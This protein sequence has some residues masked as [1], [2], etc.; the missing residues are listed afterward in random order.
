MPLK[1]LNVRII[2]VE[3]CDAHML[4]DSDRLNED[5]LHDLLKSCVV[6]RPIAWISTIGGNGLHNVA[7]FS[8]FTFVSSKPPYLGFSVA[9]KRG[10]KKGTLANIERTKDFVVNVVTEDLA[11]AV[12]LSAAEYPANISKVDAVGVRSLPG[13]N[14]KSFRIAESPI[15]MEC[16]LVDIIKIGKSQN[17]LVIGEVLTFHINDGLFQNNVIDQGSLRPLG[18]LSGD[19]YAGLGNILEISRPWLLGQ[20]RKI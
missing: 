14:V 11:R 10:S 16:K 19:Q 8:C 15:Q 5:Q 18:R 2:Y 4:I 17:S 7:P 9:S 20:E 1:S 12:N 3:K 13:V 6:P